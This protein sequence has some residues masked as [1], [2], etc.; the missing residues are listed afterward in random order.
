MNYFETSYGI[1]PESRVIKVLV[2]SNRSVL[3]Y[4]DAAGDEIQAELTGYGPFLD[5]EIH[6]KLSTDQA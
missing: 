6:T 1:I 2:F 4:L 3:Y 5:V